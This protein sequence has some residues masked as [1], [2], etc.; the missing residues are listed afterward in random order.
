MPLSLIEE[1]E[2]SVTIELKRLSNFLGNEQL[3]PA[4][5]ICGLFISAK[6]INGYKKIRFEHFIFLQNLWNPD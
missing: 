5:V 1:E 6:R 3:N 2:S 4:R